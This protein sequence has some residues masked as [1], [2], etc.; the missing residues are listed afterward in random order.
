MTA[1]RETDKHLRTGYTTGACAAAA[2]RAAIQALLNQES[3]TQVQIT[4]P[5]GKPVT[6]RV[7]CCTFDRV[8]SAGSVIKDAGDDPDVT[9]GAEIR[10]TVSWYSKP[11]IHIEG[12]EGVGTVTKPGLEIPL[13]LSAINPVPRQMIAAE[14]G[15]VAADRLSTQG[16]KV[17]I[18]VP[19]G[20]ELAK[21]TLNSR[22]GIMGGISILGTTGIVLPYS[23]SA[24]TACISRAL[25]VTV[26]CGY[27]KAVLTTGRRSERFAQK[28]LQLPEE[29]YIQASD[30]I[31][32]SL[33]ECARKGVTKVIVWGMVGKISKLA[34]GHFYT[35]ISDGAVNIELLVESTADCGLPNDTIQSL[36]GAVT[37]NHFRRMLPEQCAGEVF[38]RL[39]RMAAQKCR[40]H[41]DGVLDVECIMTD[42][43]GV[44]IGRADA[45]K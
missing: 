32:Y 6:F 36:N 9:H 31:G 28:E 34:D 3:V 16:V 43:E 29:C 41:V 33:K 25:D 13:G 12:G 8:S 44:V 2:A 19:K 45:A 1:R 38:N 10:A 17:V 39:C 40:E 27:R 7:N 30:F 14:V 26:A 20:A 23:S 35:N 42:P 18:S 24:Y 37:A 5:G 21:R 4:L 15:L 11:G 22:L